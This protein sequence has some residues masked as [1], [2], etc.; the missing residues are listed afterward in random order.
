MPFPNGGILDDLLDHK[1]ILIFELVFEV[2]RT[3]EPHH[4]DIFV[5]GIYHHYVNLVLI[6]YGP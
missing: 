1:V 4:L 6:L 2:L 5:I 3:L